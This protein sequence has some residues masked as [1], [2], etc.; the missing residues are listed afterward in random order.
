MSEP[1]AGGTP[2]VSCIYHHQTTP[3]PS[4]PQRAPTHHHWGM[5]YALLSPTSPATLIYRP[6]SWNH[7]PNPGSTVFTHSWLLPSWWNHMDFSVLPEVGG[8][9]K[10]SKLGSMELP[11]VLILKYIA[12]WT[13]PY[14]RLSARWSNI[15]CWFGT[16]NPPTQAPLCAFSPIRAEEHG[17][18]NVSHS[19]PPPVHEDCFPTLGRAPPPLFLKSASFLCLGILGLQQLSKKLK[20]K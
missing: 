4:S 8:R 7:L 12:H 9:K 20:M 17:P 1:R 14:N 6:A 10:G 11:S 19:Q 2:T 5:S 3:E 13:H 16:R 18:P 15:L